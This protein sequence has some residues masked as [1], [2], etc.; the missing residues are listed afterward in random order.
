MKLILKKKNDPA[1]V[2]KDLLSYIILDQ[3]CKGCG[4]CKRVCPAGAIS[5]E[6]KAV[7]KIDTQTCVKCGACIESCKFKAIRKG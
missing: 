2:C 4:A 1:G 5:G 7:H 3:F 6:R